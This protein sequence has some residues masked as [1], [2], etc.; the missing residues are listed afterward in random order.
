MDLPP[1][2][3]TS[4]MEE[5]SLL[6]PR[7]HLYLFPDNQSKMVNQRKHK[8]INC[9]F[10]DCSSLPDGVYGSLCSRNYFHCVNG[11]S[12]EKSCTEGLVYNAVMKQCDYKEKWVAIWIRL[13]IINLLEVW[14]VVF[15]IYCLFRCTNYSHSRHYHCRENDRFRYDVLWI[16]YWWFVNCRLFL[17]PWWIVFSRMHLSILSVFI[18]NGNYSEVPGWSCFRWLHQGMRLSTDVSNLCRIM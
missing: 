18:R 17:S 6:L 13:V 10:V 8:I 2:L 12:Y 11:V 3:L 5:Y 4:R 7:L 1:P 9:W 15:L 16:V 14:I